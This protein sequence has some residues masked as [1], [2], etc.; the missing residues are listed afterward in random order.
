MMFAHHMTP[1]GAQVYAY[2]EDIV[3]IQ[4][5]CDQLM[6][7]FDLKQN[8]RAHRIWL[9]YR[10]YIVSLNTVDNDMVVIYF[11]ILPKRIGKLNLIFGNNAKFL[12]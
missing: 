7:F 6:R 5:G 1:H 11:L 4:S 12:A 3:V 10:N 8:E 2:C 9:M